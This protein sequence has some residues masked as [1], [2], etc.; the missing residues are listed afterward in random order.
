[1]ESPESPI[2]NGPTN[3]H[4]ESVPSTS[5]ALSERDLGKKDERTGIE[6]NRRGSAQRKTH[7][8]RWMP[9]VD[10]RMTEGRREDI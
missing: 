2:L 10:V 5:E 9:V 8:I 6:F 3:C 4:P 1:M 7:G